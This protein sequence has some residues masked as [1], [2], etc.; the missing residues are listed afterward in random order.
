MISDVSDFLGEP[1]VNT[2]RPYCSSMIVF[3]HCHWHFI[4]A[5]ILSLAL[6][7]ERIGAVMVL[8]ETPV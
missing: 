5:E 7:S 2:G 3:R 8:M 1:T 6:A 4:L